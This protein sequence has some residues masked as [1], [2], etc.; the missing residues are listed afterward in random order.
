MN[1]YPFFA[2][3]FHVKQLFSANISL[4]TGRAGVKHL[5]QT[6]F[7]LFLFLIPI[8]TRILYNPSTAYIDWYFNYHLAFFVYLTDLALIT[9]F[10]TWLLYEEGYRVQGTGHRIFCLTLAFLTIAGVSLFRVEH[11][12]LGIYQLLKWLELFLIIFYVSSTFKQAS[13]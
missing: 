7:Y 6:L 10:I 1:I 5:H 2:K 4:S 9:C 11:L 8:Q 3:L 12:N 13:Q